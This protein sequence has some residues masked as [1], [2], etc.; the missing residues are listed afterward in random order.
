MVEADET[1]E[2]NVEIVFVTQEWHTVPSYSKFHGSSRRAPVDKA[3]NVAIG[4]LD[5]YLCPPLK[6]SASPSASEM[7][8]MQ[9]CDAHCLL[10]SEEF[11]YLRGHDFLL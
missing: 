2:A 9:V 6:S 1:N 11:L 10:A 4:K 3:D 7:C 8:Y 5:P